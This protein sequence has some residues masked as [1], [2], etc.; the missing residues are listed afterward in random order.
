VT[1]P[2]S[3]AA[4]GLLALAAVGLLS[5]PALARGASATLP[6]PGG[7][8]E[9]E[10]GTLRYDVATERFA[11]EDGVRLRR[12][13][14]WIRARAAV[15]DPR[16]GSVDATGG[17]LLTAP[18]RAVAADGLHAVLDGPWEARDV[19]LLVK[20]RPLDLHGAA[21]AA[22]AEG[23]G[24]NRLTLRAGRISGHAGSGGGDEPFT[25][26]DVRLT[27]CDCAGGAPSWEIRASRAE[28]TPGRSAVLSWPVLYVTPRFLFVDTPIPVLPL[29]W[30]YVPLASRQTGFLFPAVNVGSRAGWELWEPFFLTL[31]ESWDATVTA[32]Y[33]FGPPSGD[34]S[35]ANAQGKDPGVRGVGGRLEVRWAPAEGVRGEARLHYL[36][37]TL[38]Y[39]W[40]PASGD[41]LGILAENEARL[42]PGGFA[43]ARVALVGDAAYPQD[44]VGELLLR[45][46][47][48]F[49]SAVAVGWAGEHVLLE[50]D[51]SYHEQ[52]GTLAQ[53]GVPVVP[54]G[55]FGGSI[56]SFHRLPAVSATLLPLRLVGPLELSGQAGVA[57]FAPIS[58]ITDRSA[59]GIGPGERFWSGPLPL[60]PGDAW[61]PGQRLAASRAWLRAELRAP[62]AVARVLE[63][64]P[65]VAGTAAGYAFGGGAQ[66]ALANG[67]VVGGAVASTRIERTFGSG[68]DALRHAIEPRVEWRGGTGIAGPALPA[69]AY[70]EVDAAPVLPGAPC[71]APPTGIAGACLPLRSLTATLPGGFGQMRLALRNRLAAPGPSGSLTRLDVDL[72]Q[73]LDLS[74][75]DL[76]ETWVRAAAAWGPVKGGILA[77]FLA[78]G[79]TSAPGTWAPV[80]PNWLDRFTEVRVDVAAEDRRGD[81]VSF[82]FLALGSGASAAL[83]AGTDPL[84]DPRPVPYQPFAQGRAGLKVRVLGG[85]DLGYDALF[86]ARSIV[87]FPSGLGLPTVAPPGLQEQKFSASWTSPCD[88]WRGVVEVRLAENGYF[89]V[90]ASL[91]LSEV[92]GIRLSP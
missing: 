31:G 50:A 69:Y 5:V 16:D 15:Y 8:V 42:G 48:Y 57:R 27:L 74:S 13:E 61:T 9:V 78:F 58:G 4:G 77:R 65:W 90:T 39:A 84:F 62:V 71:L 7:P 34:V 86:A 2:L 3:P 32:G 26:D 45:N 66:P 12:G 55:A 25:A 64:E 40:K 80:Y 23:E 18:G 41:R 38:P 14:V 79:A 10:A 36:H 11:L 70:D 88:C 51:L 19:V 76:G 20:G 91:D 49:R 89:G 37:D 67:W 29:P 17:V 52:I 43:N 30:L 47:E 1:R 59:N 81:R 82:G 72:G 21:D 87:T 46:S 22:A 33:A 73:D 24:R 85:L 75:G 83:K 6:G 92:R 35:S 44:F 63:I 54:F 53:P 56:P 68:A 60:P 28:V